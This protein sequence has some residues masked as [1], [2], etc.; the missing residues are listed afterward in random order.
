MPIQA[1][2]GYQRTST[3]L[4][5]LVTKQNVANNAQVQYYIHTST[6]LHNLVTR[7]FSVTNFCFSLVN[8][9]YVIFKSQK[10]VIATPFDSNILTKAYTSYP[11]KK[12]MLSALLKVMVLSSLD[13][14]VT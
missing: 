1:K 11:I 6:V 4:H 12:I 9:S 5:N 14:S 13:V 2:C 7:L 3:V 8:C 10:Q